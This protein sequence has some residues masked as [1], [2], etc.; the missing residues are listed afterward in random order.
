MLAFD[1]VELQRAPERAEHALGDAMHVA[2]FQ[3]GVVRGADAGEHGDLLAPEAGNP[4]WAVVGQP[5]LVGGQLG[6]PGGEEVA[7]L[8]AGVHDLQR[9]PVPGRPGDPARVTFTGSLNRRR[10]VLP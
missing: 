2:A 6:A 5:D 3:A 9:S 1:V 4:P 10:R 7:D 8:A